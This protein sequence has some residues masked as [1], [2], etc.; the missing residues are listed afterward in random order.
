MPCN[1]TCDV[2]EQSF[3]AEVIINHYKREHPHYLCN[4]VIP[5]RVNEETG[6][7]E[8]KTHVDMN[9]FIETMNGNPCPFY[10]GED[11]EDSVYVDFSNGHGYVKHAMALK[12]VIKNAD[13]HRN[14]WFRAVYEGITPDTLV[15]M[16]K[17]MRQK[18]VSVIDTA[19]V[20]ELR[21]KL[22]TVESNREYFRN[23]NIAL[24]RQLEERPTNTIVENGRVE[25]LEREIKSLRQQ[26]EDAQGDAYER[27]NMTR[28]RISGDEI[29]Y[30]EQ[31][32]QQYEKFK[33]DFIRES[34]RESKAT[35]KKLKAKIKKLKAAAVDSDSE[36]DS[37]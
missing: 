23:E 16:L 5:L 29:E 6:R 9:T 27:Y 21:A 26:L 37:D 22:Q 7:I 35:I 12:H 8:I 28:H 2:C 1:V 30:T 20:D 31:V 10:V 34:Q 19:M 13:K 11:E 24:R 32:K 33:K 36:S 15:L 25:E 3:R 17:Y 4:R 18:P 14:H